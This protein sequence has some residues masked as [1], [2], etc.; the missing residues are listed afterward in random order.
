MDKQDYNKLAKNVLDAVGGKE[1]VLSVTHCIT[2][3]RFILKDQS[4]P[5]DKEVELISGVV[6]IMHS[7]GQYQV[8]IGQAVDQ[9]YDELCKVG[10]FSSTES[11]LEENTKG[12]KKVTLKSIGNGILDYMAGS[13]TPLIPALI[14]AA[15]FKTLAAV[16]GP[17]MFGLLS[18]T[19]DLYTLF[20]FVGDAAF[21][22]FPV[23]IG[24]TAAKKLNCSPI[25]SMFLGAILIHPTLVNMATE[26]TKFTV[27]GIPSSVQSYTAT[28]IP[29]FLSVWVLSYVEK[30]F[31]KV[32]PSMLKIVFA[33]FLT[34]LV[35]L[36]I[37]LCVLG[38]AGAFVGKYICDGLLA[39]GNF[40]GVAT[41]LAIA[42][43]GAL[44]EFLV[45]SGMHWVLI[46]TMIVVISSS[47]QESVVSAAV[48]AASFSV[49]GMCFG[50]ALRQKK[51]GDKSVSISYVVAQVIGG[52]TEP[53]L[54]GIGFRYKRPFIGMAIGG[55]AGAL[56][57][58]IV[59]LTAYNIVPVASFLCV[60]G[61][62]GG[63][64]MNFVNAII[65]G[66][67]AFVVAA[68]ATYVIGLDKNDKM[69]V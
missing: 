10:G 57:G 58:A 5:K 60:L 21:Y 9:V 55:F 34:I 23:I 26:G 12:K 53:G 30:F 42:L 67:I 36:P 63:S 51:A 31:N 54:Y 61:Y 46:S 11:A 40:G 3:L 4:I 7:A 43:I 44:W 64:T 8:V 66:V 6:G 50:A 16:L 48:V 41:F 13:L 18:K 52:V 24:Y 65:S 62:S 35:M 20:T 14:T 32:I 33:P 39:M 45:M 19:S 1:N 15:L 38:P 29:I 17:D 2:R 69:A 27:F 22:F 37:T 25:L 49:G 59:G 28:I 68:V 47:G 56:Y